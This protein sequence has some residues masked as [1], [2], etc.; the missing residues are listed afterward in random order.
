MK[1]VGDILWLALIAILLRDAA[2]LLPE[3]FAAIPHAVSSAV[4]RAILRAAVWGIVVLLGTLPFVFF[5]ARRF[6]VDL[7][8]LARRAMLV[9]SIAL[10]LLLVPYAR[11]PIRSFLESL[12]ECKRCDF[13]LAGIDLAKLRWDE[14]A[15]VS[16]FGPGCEGREMDPYLRGYSFPSLGVFVEF[17]G[18]PFI[19]Q[20]QLS[21]PTNPRDGCAAK[22]PLESITTAPG[23]GLGDSEGKVLDS[24]GLPTERNAG[25]DNRLT[26]IYRKRGY[27]FR[28]EFQEGRVVAIGVSV[29]IIGDDLRRARGLPAP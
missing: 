14:A 16:A 1:V 12:Q 27:A 29:D 9:E 5:V 20:M 4:S 7:E 26:L 2:L 8:S 19:E 28:F 17:R 3:V 10:C 25:P 15:L 21:A 23:V 13:Q 22:A 18:G 11:Y 24:Y 6:A